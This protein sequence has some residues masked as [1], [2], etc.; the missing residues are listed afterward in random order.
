MLKDISQK[1]AS[2]T[3]KIIGFD[4]IITNEDSI[5]IGS[6]DVSRLGEIHEASVNIIKTGK[7]NP[8]TV[9]IELFKGTERGFALP[10][11]ILDKR[12]GSFGITGERDEVKGYC[13]LL[14][15]YIETMLYQEMYVKSQIQHE[16]AVENLLR[17]IAV[18]NR[19]KQNES[20][21][22]LRGQELGYDL[23]LSR[24][25]L[26]LDFHQFNQETATLYKEDREGQSAPPKIQLIKKNMVQVMGNFFNRTNDI[27]A[28]YHGNKYV[29]LPTITPSAHGKDTISLIKQKC[30]LMLRQLNQIGFSAAIGI[31]AAAK[32]VHELHL[33]YKGAWRA[34]EL[35][36][37]YDASNKVHYIHDLALEDLASY[38]KNSISGAYLESLLEPLKHHQDSNELMETI[39]AWCK[40]GFSQKNAASMLFIHRNTLQYRLNKIHQIT[41]LNTADFK[42]M[43]ML[44]MSILMENSDNKL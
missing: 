36:E 29:L 23:E 3:S 22:L 20:Y 4:V 28:P 31:G 24:I 35:G 7:P 44:Y 16:H 12:I 11:E 13:Y 41:G 26:I 2:R 6:S 8:D 5:I 9:N 34:L 39:S 33:S 27:I 14:K 30:T 1:L 19:H 32:G 21:I 40:S 17:E 25:C 10:I 18:F 15:E 38:A 37:K 42:K 43:M